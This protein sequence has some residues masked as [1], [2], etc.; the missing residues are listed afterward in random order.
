MKKILILTVLSVLLLV[1]GIAFAGSPDKDDS[2]ALKKDIVKADESLQK[3]PDASIEQPE[4]YSEPE[5]MEKSA[6]E[7]DAKDVK[8]EIQ[9]KETSGKDKAAPK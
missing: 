8:A 1:G 9:K 4:A 5:E 6:E 3:Q 7:S 2:S